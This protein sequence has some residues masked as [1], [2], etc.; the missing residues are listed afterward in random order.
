MEYA[1]LLAGESCSLV[2]YIKSAAQIGQ[3]IVREA[4]EVL[5]GMKR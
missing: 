3:D 1:A 4:D 5:E 2:S